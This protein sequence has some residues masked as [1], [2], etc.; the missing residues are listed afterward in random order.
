MT[1]TS[2][3]RM[4]LVAEAAAD[5]PVVDEPPVHVGAL[6]VRG[7]Q[8]PG[9]GRRVRYSSLHREWDQQYRSPRAGY[10]YGCRSRSSGKC[11]CTASKCGLRI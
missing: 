3:H 5:V 1:L 7:N 10:S 6:L 2:Q 11:P 4:N 8:H 9:R